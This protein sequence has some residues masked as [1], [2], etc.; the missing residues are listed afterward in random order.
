MWVDTRGR[1]DGDTDQGSHTE[2]GRAVVEGGPGPP[3][4]PGRRVPLV[5][6]QLTGAGLTGLGVVD[7]AVAARSSDVAV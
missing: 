6:R 1:Q 3:G 7:S 2:E 4:E 5:S